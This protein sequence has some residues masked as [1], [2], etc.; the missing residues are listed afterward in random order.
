MGTLA[1]ELRIGNLVNMNGTPLAVSPGDLMNMCDSKGAWREIYKPIPLTEEELVKF[2]WDRLCMTEEGLLAYDLV[3]DNIINCW[4]F[5]VYNMRGDK[6][7]CATIEYIH[8]L[9]NLYFALDGE[10]LIKK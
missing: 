1:N 6:V 10:E 2:N 5:Y 7:N 4:H 9:Q 3:Y 8:Q